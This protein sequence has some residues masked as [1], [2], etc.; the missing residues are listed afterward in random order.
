MTER[1]KR[2]FEL[3]DKANNDIDM[4]GQTT[5]KT[6]NELE[7]LGNSLNDKEIEEVCKIHNEERRQFIHPFEEREV[8][9]YIDEVKNRGTQRSP[10]GIGS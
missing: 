2:F 5:D 6:A 7:E 3:Q 9:E 10:F 8:D 4:F 1:V